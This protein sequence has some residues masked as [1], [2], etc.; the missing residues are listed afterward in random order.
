MADYEY[1]FKVKF[2][3]ASGGFITSDRIVVMAG[4]ISDAEMKV[5]I[6][7]EDY[8]LEYDAESFTFKVV[9]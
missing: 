7:A 5:E 1:A 2:Y 4:N 6:E 8:M 3:D 9:D